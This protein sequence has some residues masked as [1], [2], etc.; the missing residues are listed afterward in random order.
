LHH[1]P[2]L[3]NEKD[4]IHQEIRNI[5]GKKYACRLNKRAE[6]MIES[7]IWV[8][9]LQYITIPDNIST[10]RNVLVEIKNDQHHDDSKQQRRQRTDGSMRKENPR[11]LVV[12]NS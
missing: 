12:A 2:F 1:L 4:Q 6:M 9:E 5:I 7:L 8:W 10:L 11:V 3:N